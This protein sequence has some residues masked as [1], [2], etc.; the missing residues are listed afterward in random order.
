LSRHTLNKATL[1]ILL[2]YLRAF[3]DDDQVALVSLRSELAGSVADPDGSLGLIG[4]YLVDPETGQWRSLAQIRRRCREWGLSVPKD[5]AWWPDLWS[6]TRLCLPEQ[7]QLVGSSASWLAEQA[8]RLFPAI[9]SSCLPAAEYPYWAPRPAESQQFEQS[10]STGQRPSE[11]LAAC[12]YDLTYDSISRAEFLDE[13]DRFRARRSNAGN[14]ARALDYAALI[15]LFSVMMRRQGCRADAAAL[16]FR[17]LK[18][19]VYHRAA[20]YL[21]RFRPDHL[22]P[23]HRFEVRL[24]D[25][26][27]ISALIEAPT[28]A[29]W[30]HVH[31]AWVEPV[32]PWA[33]LIEG[34][35]RPS[36]W[37]AHLRVPS[38]VKAA[39]ARRLAVLFELAFADVAPDPERVL[40]E[41][42]A[43]L[44][45][46]LP[47]ALLQLL[48]CDQKAGDQLIMANDILNDLGGIEEDPTI[49][50]Q[51]LIV[52]TP[53]QVSP[54]PQL[55]RDTAQQHSAPQGDTAR[56]A[57]LVG[58]LRVKL[59]SFENQRGNRI[60]LW[61]TD[62]DRVFELV[63][64]LSASKD[65]DREHRNRLMRSFA[66]LLLASARQDDRYPEEIHGMMDSLNPLVMTLAGASDEGLESMLAPTMRYLLE[67]RSGRDPG[68]YAALLLRA[69]TIVHSKHH[70]YAPAEQWLGAAWR[71]IRPT[72]DS[73]VGEGFIKQREAAQQVALQ[74]SG[75]YMRMLE[76]R[77][78]D[79]AHRR[80]MP[81]QADATWRELRLLARLGLGSAGFALNELTKM[82][83][84]F[85]LPDRRSR[86]RAS[87]KAWVINT[88]CMYMRGLLLQATL[89]AVEAD[90]HGT[91]KLHLQWEREHVR[92]FLDA[93]PLVYAEA[94]SQP[95][96]PTYINELT[97]IALHYAFLSGLSF[98]KPSA[99][100]TTSA[101]TQHLT[102]AKRQSNGTA[103]F[104]V[105]QASVHLLKQGHDAGILASIT[106]PEVLEALERRSQSLPAT[107]DH[108]GKSPYRL[109]LETEE[110]I[111]KLRRPI[112]LERMPQG[113]SVVAAERWQMGQDW[114]NWRWNM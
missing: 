45:D 61:V 6:H 25:T 91:G 80:A 71:V 68:P 81:S 29:V 111:E 94:T 26:K 65:L 102:T 34:L 72:L 109:W 21:D 107:G 96:T 73:E 43:P 15:E 112:R 97:R 35:Y 75:M 59:D 13:L 83:G 56:T 10:L 36:S 49:P 77:L 103:L 14:I 69:I 92:V 1:Q 87:S 67:P 7:D 17:A 2:R 11:P 60:P 86:A 82:G 113:V 66:H 9:G 22:E 110:L 58:D 88:R 40:S 12:A 27:E 31:D 105:D 30:L 55:P 28:L 70:R 85:G 19:A 4:G 89:E 106:H 16:L 47:E 76:F 64:A 44:A 79:P 20:G 5:A 108:T 33:S 46:L 95:L 48:A 51:K 52:L 42:E 8:A 41:V 114:A 104:N 78:A 62:A 3:C 84:V 53:R 38:D 18:A 99:S 101:S 63:E 54:P 98:L 90:R 50:P 57:D 32:T 100:L 23:L 93:V 74:A 24:G 39:Q 37:A